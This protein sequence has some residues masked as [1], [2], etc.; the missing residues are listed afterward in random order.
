MCRK[1]WEGAIVSQ[2]RMQV[3]FIKEQKLVKAEGAVSEREEN[4]LRRREKQKQ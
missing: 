1:Q 2:S 4:G 3:R